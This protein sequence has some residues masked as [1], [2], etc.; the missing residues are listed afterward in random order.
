MALLLHVIV[1][2]SMIV[3]F[4][5]RS[6]TPPDMPLMVTAR[7]VT[8][9]PPVAPPVV[10]E[11]PE[12]PAPE[13]E[14][15]PD[16]SEQDR[17]RAEEQKRLEDARVERERLARI[18]KAKQEAEAERQR[19]ADEERRRKEEE[20][21]REAARIEAE[22]QRQADI[23]RQ[24]QENEREK[25]RLRAEAE[26]ARRA[27]IE[28]ETNRIEAMQADAR[29][30]YMFAIKQRVMNRWAAPASATP[31]VECVANIR[32][33]PGGDVVS[34]TIGRCNGDEAVRRSIIAA[35]N[36]ASPLP[37]PK[38]P[39]VFEREVR[40]TFRPEEQN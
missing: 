3:A 16:T 40:I 11:R 25:E 15:E 7:I 6:R 22:R 9:T 35:I 17:I 13:P 32:Q 30:A 38:D 2:G 1:F 10:E 33:V 27:E 36:A 18:E 39:G 4:D 26:A 19:K 12:P 28:A 31:G 37:T 5:F 34:V 24:R 21:R 29:A 8:D 14:P 23:E 20:A